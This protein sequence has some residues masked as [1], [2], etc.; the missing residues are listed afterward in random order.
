ME[1]K[2]LNIFSRIILSLDVQ[3]RPASQNKYKD[4]NITESYDPSIKGVFV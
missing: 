3:A 1:P 2:K 4:Y